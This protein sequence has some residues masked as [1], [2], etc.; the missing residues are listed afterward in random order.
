MAQRSAV[1]SSRDLFGLTFLVGLFLFSIGVTNAAGDPQPPVPLASH[2][3]VLPTPSSGAPR[4]PVPTPPPKRD[5]QAHLIPSSPVPP[6]PPPNLSLPVP[7]DTGPAATIVFPNST[8]VRT[9][10]SRGHFRLTGIRALE[11][12]RVHFRF[13]LSFASTAMIVSALDGGEVNVSPGHD[14]VAADG[15]ASL[16]FKAGDHPGL[17]RVLLVAGGNR[18]LLKFW[19]ADPQNPKANPPHLQPGI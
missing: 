4:I 2:P 9:H 15:T 11:M 7:A 16:Q 8:S 13:P 12:V 3:S 14:S 10:S 5:S 6:V 19:V 17:Y 18:S 1:K